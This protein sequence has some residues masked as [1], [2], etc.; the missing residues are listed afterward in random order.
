[1]PPSRTSDLSYA[2]RR[3]RG[4]SRRLSTLSTSRGTRCAVAA[5]VFLVLLSALG[6]SALA[7]PT[8]DVSTGH[9]SNEGPLLSG[10]GGPGAGE[11]VILGTEQ[12]NGSHG[13]AGGG[14][15]PS[16][17]GIRTASSQSGTGSRGGQAAHVSAVAAGGAVGGGGTGSGGA[18]ASGSGGTSGSGAAVANRT[19]AGAERSGPAGDPSHTARH[20]E[21]GR[22]GSSPAPGQRASSGSRA[23]SA[24]ADTQSAAVA[25]SP[26]GLSA[27]DFAA[28]ALVILALVALSVFT[29]RAAGPR[30]R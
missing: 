9:G 30:S 8:T 14:S 3:A 6:G 21:G 1:M 11:Q 24:P 28:L 25:A 19:T 23:D 2:S 15:G 20:S 5:V 29:R 10:Y 22:G 4:R 26:P 17:A 7:S 27:T 18:G 13:E 16:R 12:S